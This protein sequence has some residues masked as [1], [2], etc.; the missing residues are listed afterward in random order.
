LEQLFRLN[1]WEELCRP[2]MTEIHVEWKKEMEEP[3]FDSCGSQIADLMTF[4]DSHLEIHKLMLVKRKHPDANG[5]L[6]M[7]VLEY[8]L[9][10]LKDLPY[11]LDKIKAEELTCTDVIEVHSLAARLRMEKLKTENGKLLGIGSLLMDMVERRHPERMVYLYSKIESTPFYYKKG[12]RFLDPLENVPRHLEDVERWMDL[13]NHAP[14]EEV[15]VQDFVN[16]HLENG[17]KND[18]ITFLHIDMYKMAPKV[19]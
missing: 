8:E 14:I 11:L 13:N 19:E 10:Q 5:H 4:G 1:E 16:E 18:I 12:Y 15:S 2:E 6:I 7:G 3:L 9:A 17:R